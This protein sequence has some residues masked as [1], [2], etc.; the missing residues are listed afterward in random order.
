MINKKF[1]SWASLFVCVLFVFIAFGSEDDKN[2]SSATIE[3]NIEADSISAHT[4]ST[5]DSISTVDKEKAEKALKN[6]KKKV[7]EFEGVTF[8]KAPQAPTYSD[9]NFVYPYIGNK[10]GQYWL[11][12]R[13]QYASDSWLF[14]NSAILMIDG[15]KFDIDGNWERD[16][17]SDI[18]E[19]LD[20]PV[21]DKE[22]QILKKIADSKTTKIRYIGNQYHDDRTIT[23]KEK[24]IIKKTLEI[25]DI[26][27]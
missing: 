20:I 15:E 13:F 9:V 26:V 27:K 17:D 14:I 12:L 11:R 21:E 10:E 3:N 23:A 18:W 5:N 16:H 25:Y 8:Y 2:N 7:D 4:Q 24:E 19:W 22:Y 1:K 6:F